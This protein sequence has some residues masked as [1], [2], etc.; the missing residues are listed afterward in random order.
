M[1]KLHSQIVYVPRAQILVHPPLKGNTIWIKWPKQITCAYFPDRRLQKLVEPQ[2][3]CELSR[4]EGITGIFYNSYQSEF[5][6]FNK[7]GHF[8]KRW[9]MGIFTKQTNERRTFP[10]DLFYFLL[11]QHPPLSLL[12]WFDKKVWGGGERA[13]GRIKDS[14]KVFVKPPSYLR[15]LPVPS[16]FLLLPFLCTAHFRFRWRWNTQLMPVISN[17]DDHHLEYW[18]STSQILMIIIKLQFNQNI[19]C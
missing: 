15:F 3:D 12:V 18:W 6:I 9:K 16:L 4:S 2:S 1:D 14:V 7:V 10:L 17:T 5:G 19:Y 11:A 13:N 8:S